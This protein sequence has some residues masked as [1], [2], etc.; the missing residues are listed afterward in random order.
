MDRGDGAA[1]RHTSTL[2]PSKRFAEL[3]SGKIVCIIFV[4]MRSYVTV[5]LVNFGISGSCRND[6]D[7]EE[8]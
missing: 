4:D 2:R 1:D 5:P 6:S 7:D 3:A 8:C